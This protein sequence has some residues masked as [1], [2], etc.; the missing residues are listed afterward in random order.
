MNKKN[1]LLLLLLSQSC[2]MVMAQ[3]TVAVQQGKSELLQADALR[4]KDKFE[5]AIP[6]LQKAEAIFERI[7]STADLIKIGR[8]H[9]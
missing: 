9:V 6:H 1:F 7:R 8:A 4:H 3:D 2:L 5:E